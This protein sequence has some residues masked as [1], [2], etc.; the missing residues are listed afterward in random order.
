MGCRGP[1]D[2]GASLASPRPGGLGSRRPCSSRPR[3]AYV[4]GPESIVVP[5]QLSTQDTV[6]P[7][8]P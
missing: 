3:L 6:Q 5:V 8:W 4:S 2:A 1:D 7:S